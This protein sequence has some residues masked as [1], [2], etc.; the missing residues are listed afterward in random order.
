MSK[1]NWFNGAERAAWGGPESPEEVQSGK[2][3]D[4][5][6]VGSPAP[7]HCRPLQERGVKV[8]PYIHFGQ[9][10][11][12]VDAGYAFPWQ[13]HPD[14]LC[15]DEDGNKVR[16]PYLRPTAKPAYIACPNVKEYRQH[17][18]RNLREL[19]ETGPDGVFIDGIYATPCAGERLGIHEHIYH[20]VK[21]PAVLPRRGYCLSKSRRD[22]R[23]EIGTEEPDQLYAG[24][25]LQ[26]ECYEMVKQYGQD[27]ILILNCGDTSTLP[28]MAWDYLDC[29]MNEIFMFCTY[30]DWS[31]DTGTH[32]DCENH[33]VF[34]WLSVLEWDQRFIGRG[35]RIFN[36]PSFSPHDP[37]SADHVVYSFAVSSAY[38]C[39]FP[40]A[41]D[42]PTA[43]VSEFRLGVPLDPAPTWI[44]G[45][46]YRE[47]RNGAVAANPYGVA[48][49]VIVP[50][51]GK[52]DAAVQHFGPASYDRPFSDGR[53]LRIEADGSLVIRVN[54]ARGTVLTPP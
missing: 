8:V 53:R 51:R 40:C 1:N 16:N 41:P 6:F 12:D 48:Q 19:M 50:W 35:K 29:A 5:D 31:W 49:R 27:R 47:F 10:Y 23:M 32:L 46:L 13:E 24:I 26:K 2:W 22:Q 37:R 44:G 42:G 38:N 34:D 3:D 7:D 18:L 52:S 54:P 45:V 25:M 36:L 20:G 43:V 21:D 17:C 11:K 15:Y 4:Y 28:D 30:L 39:L 14:W 9:V 33:D